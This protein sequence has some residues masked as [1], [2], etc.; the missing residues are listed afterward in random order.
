MGYGV[1]VAAARPVRAKR[2]A[3]LEKNVPNVR[4]YLSVNSVP[5]VH[6]YK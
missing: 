6:T 2:G 1:V 3:S 5:E 4:W